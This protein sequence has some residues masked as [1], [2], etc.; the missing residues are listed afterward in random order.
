MPRRNRIET[1]LPEAVRRW[2]D[3]A[4]AEENFSGY[5]RLA[6]ALKERGYTISKSAIHRYGAKLERKLAAIKASTEAMRMIADAT[7]DGQDNRSEAL[8]A[9]IQTELF[10]TLVNLREAAED[11]TDPV[12]RT[13]MLAAAAKNIATL[14]RSSVNL[15]RYQAEA[16]EQGRAEAR[17]EARARLERMAPKGDRPLSEMTT[18]ELEAAI[19]E[20]LGHGG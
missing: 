10:E 4:L 2:L 8:T 6:D 1:D 16:R 9:L 3:R 15:K 20:A 18:E 12:E 17:A 7:P 13:K 11:E 14:T 5:E 19:V